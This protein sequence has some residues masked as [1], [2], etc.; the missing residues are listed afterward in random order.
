ML[1]QDLF[2]QRALEDEGLVTADQLDRV[3]RYALEHSVDLVDALIATETLSSRRIALTRA[4]VSEVPYVALADYEA[5]FANTSILPR[6]V[7][8]RHCAYPLFLID[9][10]L[11]V[12]MDDPLNLDATDQIRQVA[13]CQVDAVLAEREIIR[14]LI[15]K[16]YSIGHAQA[17]AAPASQEIETGRRTTSRASRSSRR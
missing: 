1:D 13:R 4:N 11:T 16:A 5:C 2:L 9:D 7:A 8:E 3:R 14:A 17:G 12:A 6:S 15:A 10:V